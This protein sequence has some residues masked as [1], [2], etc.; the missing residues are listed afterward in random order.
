MSGD[1]IGV[2]TERHA[3]LRFV[4]CPFPNVPLLTRVVVEDAGASYL[5]FV[6]LAADSIVDV[7]DAV[8]Q[9][10]VVA[11]GPTSDIVREAIEAIERDDF[12]RAQ[13][14]A[15]PDIAV[16]AASWSTDLARLDLTM[17]TEADEMTVDL[18]QEALAREFR[19]EIRFRRPADVASTA[20]E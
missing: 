18:F 15:P 13:E 5:A 10:G 17:E 12:L 2:R 1:I 20:G 9:G 4:R 11:V 6:A 19:A 7:A 16:L 14:L 3:P 8:V